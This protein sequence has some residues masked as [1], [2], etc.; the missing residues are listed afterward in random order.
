MLFL[1]L[2]ASKAKNRVRSSSRKLADGC[3]AS[4]CNTQ[5][6]FFDNVEKNP[7]PRVSL[8][9]TFNARIVLSRSIALSLISCSLASFPH[10]SQIAIALT[11]AREITRRWRREETCHDYSRRYCL[12][13]PAADTCRFDRRNRS[14]NRSVD[15]PRSDAHRRVTRFSMAVRCR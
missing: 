8:A 13:M 7:Q 5:T 3:G 15:V 4:R 1:L 2:I 9:A 12:A 11:P 10:F 14:T 6:L